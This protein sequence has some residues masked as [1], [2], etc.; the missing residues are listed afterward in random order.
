MPSPPR[1]RSGVVLV[2][3]DATVLRLRR[4]RDAADNSV[5]IAEAPWC[6]FI[7]SRPPRTAVP[8]GRSLLQ[9]R[10]YCAVN[11]NRVDASRFCISFPAETGS[12]IRTRR[13][14]SGDTDGV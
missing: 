13:R 9:L 3:T 2:A 5:H 12:E 11:V 1:D 4:T 6:L 8:G 14:D 7:Q 10:P